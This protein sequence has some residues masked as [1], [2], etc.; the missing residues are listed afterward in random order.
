[1]A[2]AKLHPKAPKTLTKP[3]RHSDG[4]GL[5]LN[6]KKSGA[7]SWVFI[8]KRKGKTNERGLGGINAVSLS[9]ARE[10]AATCR[11]AVADGFDPRDVLNPKAG[12]TFLEA[13]TSLM[14][15][16]GIKKLSPKSVYQ[17]ERSLLELMEPLHKE[18][19]ADITTVDVV[20]VLAPIWNTTPETG[21]RTRARVEGVFSYAK[22]MG[23]RTADNP[24]AFKGTLEHV[25]EKHTDE[26]QHFAALPYAELPAFMDE[27]KTRPALSA[28]LMEFTILTA[29][30][31]SEACGASWDEIDLEQQRWTIPAERMKKGKAHIVPLSDAAIDVLKPL[32]AG[33]IS[34]WVFPSPSPKTPLS[35][36]AMAALLKRM[37]RKDITV[38]GWRSTFR[39]W[40][41]DETAFSRDVIEFSLSH[42]VGDQA[43][44]SYRRKTALEKR[45]RL[46]DAWGD[47]CL[48]NA[49][50]VVR[51]RRT[52]TNA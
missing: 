3:G 29:A 52:Q 36:G 7:K 23:W 26:V 32:H 31:T 51:L 16:K 22:V 24:A 38:H 17:W 19:I 35:T 8:Y 13:A 45:T 30:R 25:L 50:N 5:Y 28:R 42:I 14:D 11:Q 4:G 15:K 20:R 1:M 33:R 43:E 37:G 21:R 12:K 10:L 27:L 2:L 44:R 39:D 49:G 41:G 48:D 18:P 6:I 40:A 34:E 47:Y 9:R 46:M